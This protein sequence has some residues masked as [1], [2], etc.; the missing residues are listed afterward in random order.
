MS[1]L[2]SQEEPPRYTTL[3]GGGSDG[4]WVLSGGVPGAV[5]AHEGGCGGLLHNGIF[6]F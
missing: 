1:H 5:V 4:W 2:T 6:C 3:C